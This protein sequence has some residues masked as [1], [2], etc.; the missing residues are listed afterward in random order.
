MGSKNAPAEGAV[1]LPWAVERL[2]DRIESLSRIS[3]SAR[4]ELKGLTAELESEILRFLWEAAEAAR[5]RQEKSSEEIRRLWRMVQRVRD[6]LRRHR[7]Q[8]LQSQ[9]AEFKE[10][11]IRDPKTRLLNHSE[12]MDR[13]GKNLVCSQPG[14]YVA[15]GL[16]DLTDFGKVNEELGHDVGDLVIKQVAQL[17]VDLVRSEDRSADLVAQTEHGRFGG[18]E[19]CFFIP[20]LPNPG[21]AYQ[22]AERFRQAV[23]DFEW[24]ELNSSIT[25]SITVDIGVV[26]LS[27]REGEAVNP[28]QLLKRADQLMYQAKREREPGILERLL[29]WRSSPNVQMQSVYLKDGQLVPVVEDDEPKAEP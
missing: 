10:L 9:L 20:D 5:I 1:Q 16:L 25:R 3:K 6:V 13:V 19:F 17:L 4:H 11:A 26:C 14:L 23:E 2:K 28:S 18:D 27:V 12:F 8:T 21:V 7:L 29:V 15:L 22:I 24:R